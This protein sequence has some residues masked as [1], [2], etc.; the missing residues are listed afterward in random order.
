MTQ[1]TIV[2]QPCP[3][4]PFN[5]QCPPGHLGGSPP[6]VYIGQING[7]F[8]LPCHMH[9]EFSDPNWKKDMAKPQCAGAATFRANLGIADRMPAFF[10]AMPEDRARV[11]ASYEEFVCYHTDIPASVVTEFLKHV[12][13]DMLTMQALSVAAANGM[14][15]RKASEI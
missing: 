15:P 1:P 9:T 2:R 11:F 5:R 3:E 13:P 12:T 4:C 14:L 7:P 6:D 10:L 8:Y